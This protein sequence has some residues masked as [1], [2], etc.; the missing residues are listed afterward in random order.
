MSV[1]FTCKR[2][3][4]VCQKLWKRPSVYYL[5]DRDVIHVGDLPESV[6]HLAIDHHFTQRLTP[7]ILPESITELSLGYS[8]NTHI[9][10][11]TLPSSL[12][13]LSFT[14]DPWF[15]ERKQTFKPGCSN[16]PASLTSLTLGHMFDQSLAPGTL[17]HSITTL[18]LGNSFDHPLTAGVLP[19]SLTRLVFGH[20]P[21]GFNQPTS[22]IVLPLGL[23]SLSLGI[24]FNQVI[25]QGWLPPLLERLSFGNHYQQDISPDALPASLQT[26]SFRKTLRIKQLPP[27]ALPP[28]LTTLK[29]PTNYNHPFAPGDLPST[30]STLVLGRWFNREWANNSLPPSLTSLVVGDQHSMTLLALDSQP[31][32]LQT[33][34]MCHCFLDVR[35]QP[36]ACNPS[37]CSE[38]D[39]FIPTGTLPNSIRTL[40]FGHSFNQPLGPLT[41][42][43]SLTNLALGAAFQ[44]DVDA[45]VF[46]MSLTRLA[47]R[48][49]PVRL[50]TSIK[51]LSLREMDQ[52]CSMD[53]SPCAFD[54]V[55]M[56][57]MECT[58]R[59]PLQPTTL[60]LR[61]VEVQFGVLSPFDES[62]ILEPSSK[63][64]S[65]VVHFLRDHFM[66]RYQLPYVLRLRMEFV[67]I[68][69]IVSWIDS[70]TALLVLCHDNVHRIWTTNKLQRQ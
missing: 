53:T 56:D 61:A 33:L 67:N 49:E 50:P 29:L 12:Q 40:S 32:S 44:Q 7:G 64:T 57:L 63:L 16:L 52:L 1:A 2:C 65:F 26:L 4:A 9:D 36:C 14:N 58:G 70:T 41:L 45:Q 48:G 60:S 68:N 15:N 20:E 54:I 47:L 6:T 24:N 27:G 19:A 43:S 13:T 11:A 55:Q 23:R 66:P 3:F 5:T 18:T 38:F 28:S 35:G 21:P 22:L 8:F 17:P 30:L 51:H 37:R 39:C 46:P 31:C 10:P 62:P 69:Y 34:A 25:P 42:P 59:A